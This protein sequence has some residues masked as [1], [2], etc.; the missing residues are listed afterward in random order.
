MAGIFN[1]PWPLPSHVHDVAVGSFI[2]WWLDTVFVDRLWS[3][4]SDCIDTRSSGSQFTNGLLRSCEIPLSCNYNS[5]DSTGSQICTCHD[6]LAVVTCAK[7]W[8]DRI[9]GALSYPRLN[10]IFVRI[11][12]CH[13]RAADG[14]KPIHESVVCVPVYMAHRPICLTIGRLRILRNWKHITVMSHERWCVSNHKQTD[15][16]FTNLFRLTTT[17]TKNTPKLGIAEPLWRWRT[18]HSHYIDLIYAESVTMS[19]LL[20]WPLV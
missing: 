19:S 17:T 7:F 9:I 11:K 6:S 3:V 18:V 10:I 16:S 20:P 8:H 13:L 12:M 15:C 1:Y 4:P 2:G 5:N 14:G